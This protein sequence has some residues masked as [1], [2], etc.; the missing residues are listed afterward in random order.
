MHSQHRD[1]D[2]RSGSLE[3]VLGQEVLVRMAVAPDPFEP[4]SGSGGV[5]QRKRRAAALAH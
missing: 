4:P 3:L 2:V 5:R 1:G